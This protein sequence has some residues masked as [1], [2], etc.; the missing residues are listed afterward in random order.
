ME[1]ILFGLSICVKYRSLMSEC[2]ASYS[3]ESPVHRKQ[4]INEV[5]FFRYVFIC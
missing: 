1:K 5:Y 3:Q 2:V 4:E